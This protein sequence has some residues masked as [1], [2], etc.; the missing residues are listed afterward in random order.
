MAMPLILFLMMMGLMACVAQDHQTQND[1]R[2]QYTVLNARSRKR[3]WHY[4]GKRAGRMKPRKMKDF[5]TGVNSS[6]L[7]R[8]ER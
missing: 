8:P 1:Q 6:N 7:V 3:N 2:S 5:V 4:R